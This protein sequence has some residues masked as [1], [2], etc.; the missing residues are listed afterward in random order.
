MEV[1]EP[2]SDKAKPRI[3]Q[4]LQEL[5]PQQVLMRHWMLDIHVSTVGALLDEITPSVGTRN[6]AVKGWP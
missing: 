3:L 1:P 5:M 4:S 6:V 2:M